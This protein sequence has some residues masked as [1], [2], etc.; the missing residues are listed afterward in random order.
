MKRLF[1][2]LTLMMVLLPAAYA[3][4]IVVEKSDNNKLAV[5][6][7]NFRRITFT[8]N[9]VNI[10]DNVGEK[11]L[12][13]SDITRIYFDDYTRINEVDFNGSKELV[14]YITPDEIAVNCE[15]G[16]V[17]A[18]YNI[19]GSIVLKARQESEGGSISIANLPKGIYL[20]RA[21]KQTVKILKK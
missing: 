14:A 8:G 6:L 21:G 20:L 18:I 17:I 10:M 5:D 1:T 4:R 3:Q 7:Q 16:E 11:S 12:E 9:V 15:A 2:L 19:S 13:M